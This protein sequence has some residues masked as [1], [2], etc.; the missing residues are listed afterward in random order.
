MYVRLCGTLLDRTGKRDYTIPKREKHIGGQ[1]REH[2]GE[3]P[4]ALGALGR[5][6]RRAGEMD[7]HR[8]RGGR[9][10]RRRRRGLPHRRGVG[11]GAAPCPSPSPVAAACGRRVDHPSLPRPALGRGGDEQDHRVGAFWQECAHPPCAPHLRRH[12]LDPLGGRLGRKRG[13]GTSAWR[14]HRL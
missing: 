14:K 13:S 4:Q 1:S 6:C 8:L 12:V 3:D 5:I 2:L 10:G 11:H 9:C 7:R